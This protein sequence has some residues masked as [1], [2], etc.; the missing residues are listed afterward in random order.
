[1]AACSVQYLSIT[2]FASLCGLK[3][4]VGETIVHPAVRFMLTGLQQAS[5][6]GTHR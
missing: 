4:M 5:F 6:L 2:I 1:M 3:E